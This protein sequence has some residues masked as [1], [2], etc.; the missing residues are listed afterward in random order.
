MQSE[1]TSGRPALESF[2]G[3]LALLARSHW[4][5]RLQGKLDP[6]DVVQ[7]TLVQAWQ[8]LDGFRG[9]TDGEVRAWLRRILTHCLADHARSFS[10]D[11]RS[12]ARERSLED[13]VT[14]SSSRLEAWLDDQQSSPD[15]RA[16]RAEQLV[17]LAAALEALPEAQQEVIA[18]HHLHGLGLAEIGQLIGR[19]PAAVGG[20][21]KRGL[22]T[23]RSEIE[24]GG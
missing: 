7:Q 13:Q 21:L 1:S 20:L 19:T 5:P 6:S 24:L 14:E 22:R 2:R 9:Q 11:K 10:R 12:L 17:E 16:E 18:L 23:L 4:N 8:G 3:Y 15:E